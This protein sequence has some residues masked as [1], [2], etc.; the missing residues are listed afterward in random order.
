MTELSPLAWRL[1]RCL[2]ALERDEVQLGEVWACFLSTAP[3]LLT[4]PQRRRVLRDLL[5]ELERANWLAVPA[6]RA[7]HDR[8]DPPLPRRVGVLPASERAQ[9]LGATRAEAWHPQMA[10]ARDVEVPPDVL[11]D[12][13]RISRWLAA[14]A[15]AAVL[16]PPRERS[17]ELFG[18]G[19][20]HRLH[21]LSRTPLFDDGRLSWELLCCVPVPPPFVWSR[22][23]GGSVLLVVSG[24]ET[25]ASLRRVLV[26]A[27]ASAVGVVAHGAGGHFGTAVTFA[28]TLDRPVGRI[29]YYG[30]IAADD[31]QTAV[32]ADEAARTAGLP[33]V[34]PAAPLFRLLLD[35]GVPSPARPLRVGD[36]AAL[37]G[38]LPEDL[39]ERA[40]RLL[41]R[42]RRLAQEWVGYRLLLRA[43]VWEQLGVE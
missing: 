42:G 12:L 37:A 35:H 25:F 19:R 8:G 31:L 14:D 20:E 5:D 26:E 38:W 33:G 27:P 16:V 36:A 11:T 34:E 30:D 10:W 6:T 4:L 2:L 29:L 21:T 17:L 40:T 41:V 15:A 9:R 24:H 13:L 18:A 7:A 1:R 23:G 28:A 39:R 43:R 22:V 3:H 32:Q